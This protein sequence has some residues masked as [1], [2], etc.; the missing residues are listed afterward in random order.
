VSSDAR[1]YVWTHSPYTGAAFAIH[2]ALGDVANDLHEHRLWMSAGRLAKKARTT[3]Q[4]T[5]ATLAKLCQDGFLERISPESHQGRPVEYRFLMPD[6]PVAYDSE[7]KAR[8]GSRDT[9]PSDV[10]ADLP[11][12]VGSRDT[13]PK[14]NQSLEQKERA[15]KERK[16][17]PVWDG[18]VAWLG[19]AEPETRDERG[20]WNVAAKQL[21]DIGVDDPDEIVR[22]G[23]MYERTYQGAARTPNALVSRWGEFGR[24]VERVSPPSDQSTFER[25]PPPGEQPI[26]PEE[27]EEARVRVLTQANARRRG[28]S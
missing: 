20:K 23:R 2:L 14:K 7:V 9:S 11:P 15:T 5:A 27:S 21:R 12:R 22:R 25:T 8:V 16:A 28:Q 4:T 19:R 1:G 10:S 17:D 3:R 13:E 6:V 26:T 18:F 24:R